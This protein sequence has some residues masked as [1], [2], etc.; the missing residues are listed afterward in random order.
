MAN[1]VGSNGPTLTFCLFSGF[2]KQLF[3]SCGNL[4]VRY[5][6]RERGREHLLLTRKSG[7]AIVEKEVYLI[8]HF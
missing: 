1:E 3:G 6:V 5:F 8:Q 2:S 7:F 4:L